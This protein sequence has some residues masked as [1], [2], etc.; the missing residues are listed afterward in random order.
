M[1]ANIPP[2]ARDQAEPNHARSTK[3]STSDRLRAAPPQPFT[4]GD[5][6]GELASSLRGGIVESPCRYSFLICGCLVPQVSLCL[7]S[8]QTSRRDCF[9]L[10]HRR[11]RTASRSPAQVIRRLAGCRP[12]RPVPAGARRE[13]G[14]KSWSRLCD[15]GRCFP[16]RLRLM[17]SGTDGHRVHMGSSEGKGDPWYRRTRRGR[18]RGRRAPSKRSMRSSPNPTSWRASALEDKD[19]QVRAVEVPGCTPDLPRTEARNRPDRRRA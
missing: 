17:P 7:Q 19:P 6:D 2:N 3:L 14:E 16:D 18:R 12:F 8:R 1:D 13:I 11:P 4:A 5:A 10:G 15:F 9:S